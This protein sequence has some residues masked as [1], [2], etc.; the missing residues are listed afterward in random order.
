ME[1][2][3][4]S[5]PSFH[6]EMQLGENGSVS[7]EEIFAKAKEAW[8]RKDYATSFPAFKMLADSGYAEAYGY[9]GIAYELGE[10]VSR[11]RQMAE[12]LYEMDI[13]AHSHVGVYRMA[14]RY[15]QQGQDALLFALYQRAIDGG[16][17][18]SDDYLEV[19]EMLETGRAG[20][21]DLQRAVEYYRIAF[22]ADEGICASEA[23][24][25]LERLGALYDRGDFDVILPTELM[26]ADAG[27]LY[28]FGK[29]KANDFSKPDIPFAFACFLAAADMGHALAAYKVSAIYA[30]RKYPIFDQRKAAE[31]A[32]IA[33]DGMVNLV[34]RDVSYAFD[35]G[36]AYSCGEG[37]PR[38]DEMAQICFE[39]GA[40]DGDKNCQWKLGLIYKKN[41]DDERAVRKFWEA[42]EQGQGMAMF[43]LAQ[44]YEMGIGTPCDRSQAI[45]WYE[46]CKDSQYAAASDAKSRL[47]EIERDVPEPHVPNT[48]DSEEDKN[49][50]Q[51][52]RGFFRSLFN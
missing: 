46:R 48:L 6:T 11:N 43:E 13:K 17:A 38:D 20:K 18:T 36:V 25:A 31:Y 42:A 32:K 19:A 37:C 4:T 16:F 28:S 49:K 34:R 29:D 44:C 39:L 30:N 26:N 40:S 23:R 12:S 35:A 33:S 24:D 47:Q 3:T 45:L 9:L 8:D 22:R 2:F 50:P 7:Y 27:S 21:R 52:V 5:S 10:G 1:S 41:G 51:G 14:L 15:K